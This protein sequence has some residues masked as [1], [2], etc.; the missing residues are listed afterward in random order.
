MEQTST[1]T[2]RRWLTI[3]G[4]IVGPILATVAAI[5]IATVPESEDMRESFTTMGEHANTLMLASLIET[6]GFAITALALIAAT[7]LVRARGGAVATIGAV[8]AGCGI[9][10]FGLANGTGLAVTALATQPDA[11]SAYSFAKAITGSGPLVSGS[12]IG[13]I[14]ELVG[15]IGFALVFLGLWRGRVTPVWPFVLCLVGSLANGAIPA[16]PTVLA[17]TLLA[18]VAGTWAAVSIARA[19]REAA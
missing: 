12:S 11:D 2:V 7:S 10:G 8:M 14:L 6:A 5:I 17:S 16:P 18:L 9:A 13:W 3:I 1:D 19:R 15:L 4:L